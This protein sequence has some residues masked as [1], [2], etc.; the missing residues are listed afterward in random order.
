MFELLFKYP[1]SV[2]R[3]AELVWTSG[4]SL[5]ALYVCL[6]VAA[7]LIALSLVS[8]KLGLGRRIGLGVLQCIA[9]FV[10]LAMLWQPA[11][12]TESM[13]AGENAVAY[14]LD[15]SASMLNVD[16]AAQSRLTQ[17]SELLES[18]IEQTS[19]AFDATV[20]HVDEALTVQTET[21]DV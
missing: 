4:W 13:Q 8:R 19:N 18:S 5:P 14:L 16:Q 2:W 6:A 11:L 12:R 20:Y 10:V 9:A 21:T 17:A 7:V 1:I 3:Q 15:T